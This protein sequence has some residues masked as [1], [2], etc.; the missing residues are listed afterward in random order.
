MERERERQTE[1]EEGSQSLERMT[2]RGDAS[3][4]FSQDIF[5]RVG[6][7]WMQATYQACRSR[8]P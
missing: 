4:I 8:A 2:T 6:V 1:R 7:G 3:L 5:G